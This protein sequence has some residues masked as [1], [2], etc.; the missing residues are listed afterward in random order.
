MGALTHLWVRRE[1]FLVGT[2]VCHRMVSSDTTVTFLSSTSFSSR[3]LALDVSFDAWGGMTEF[4]ASRWQPSEEVAVTTI[5]FQHGNLSFDTRR[6]NESLDRGSVAIAATSSSCWKVLEAMRD[7]DVSC[8][9]G[10]L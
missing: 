4:E 10:E 8:G 7:F 9:D 2:C 5:S 3:I 1:T 6:C